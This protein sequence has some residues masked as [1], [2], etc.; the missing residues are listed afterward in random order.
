MFSRTPR[1][2]S[3]CLINFVAT[4]EERDHLRRV[5]RDRGTTVAALIRQGLD[6]L[7]GS[8]T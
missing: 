2:R 4:P 6:L 3:D 5:A 1:P 7:L 8:G